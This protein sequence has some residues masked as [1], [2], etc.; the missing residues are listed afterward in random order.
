MWLSRQILKVCRPYFSKSWSGLPIRSGLVSVDA[1]L[2]G[3]GPQAEIYGW[4]T[5]GF[6]MKDL[7][8]TQSLL[9]ELSGE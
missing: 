4:F 7:Q 9:E 6:E 2:S 8:E 3:A 1:R 5:E